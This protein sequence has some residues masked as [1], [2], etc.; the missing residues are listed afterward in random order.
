MAKPRT[1]DEGPVF[2]TELEVRRAEAILE[3]LVRPIE[4]LPVQPGDPIRP[5]AIG[6][7]DE[8]R[9]LLKPELTVS[10]LRRATAGFVYSRRYYLACAQADAKRHDLQ[11]NIV[12]EVSK[13]DRLA[14][15]QSFLEL[16]AAH[17]SPPEKHEPKHEDRNS[18]ILGGLLPRKHAEPNDGG[19]R[20]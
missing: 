16:Q 4:I 10:K 14:A 7:F 2:A 18:R 9:A 17:A 6:L 8:I 13:Q 5:F 20:G 15:Q 3:M 11:G 19:S 1:E 12:G